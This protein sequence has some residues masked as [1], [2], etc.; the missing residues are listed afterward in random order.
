MFPLSPVISSHNLG[1]HMMDVGCVV[2]HLSLDYMSVLILDVS[3]VTYRR[4]H[5]SRRT[6][7]Q[8]R[9][10]LHVRLAN[11]MCPNMSRDMCWPLLTRA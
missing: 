4:P 8:L 3:I 11:Y 5:Y 10:A 7:A 9:W 1:R 6:I 2:N